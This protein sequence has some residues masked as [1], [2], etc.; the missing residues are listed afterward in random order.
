LFHNYNVTKIWFE[1]LA[2]MQEYPIRPAC[3]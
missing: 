2:L 1:F 3:L